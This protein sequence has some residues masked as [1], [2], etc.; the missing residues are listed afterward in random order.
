MRRLLCI[1]TKRL[2][3]RRYLDNKRTDIVTLEG[4]EITPEFLRE[5]EAFRLYGLSGVP[6]NPEP[7][8][9]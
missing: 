3:V 4:N 2:V 1:D 7:Q 6:H 9:A 8:R 5:L